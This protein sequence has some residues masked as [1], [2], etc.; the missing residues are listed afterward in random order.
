VPAHQSAYTG[1]QLQQVPDKDPLKGEVVVDFISVPEGET[2]NA[3][4]S[5]IMAVEKQACI[6]LAKNKRIG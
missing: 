4:L 2:K 6:T 5:L 3:Y 1:A